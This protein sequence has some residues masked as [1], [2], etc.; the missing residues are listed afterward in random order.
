[1]ARKPCPECGAE[2]SSKARQCPQC[3][4]PVYRGFEW[5][6]RAS[7][8]GYPLVHVAFG[9]S[10]ETGRLLVAKGVVA[11]GQFGIGAITF[12]Q[13]GIGFVFG[14]GQCVLGTIAVGQLALGISFG[15]GQL[16]TGLTAIGQVALGR[17][18]L[19]QIGI[20]QYVWSPKVRDPEAVEHFRAI[21]DFLKSL[22]GR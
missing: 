18:V 12:A 21:W 22:A 9:R 15:L 3:G 16:A 5:K 7:V 13:F 8:L 19:A 2:I 6:S 20:G 1:M 10:K 11:I 4:H 14:F 17:H